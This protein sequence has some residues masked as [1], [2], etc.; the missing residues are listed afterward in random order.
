MP[1]R[2][3]FGTRLHDKEIFMEFHEKSNLVDTVSVSLEL[4]TRSRILKV[5]DW[6]S[7]QMSRHKFSTLVC[8]K[9]QSFQTRDSNFDVVYCHIASYN[10]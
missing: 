6:V 7:Q 1:C 9:N 2:H 10:R 3:K 4:V 5:F 8:R